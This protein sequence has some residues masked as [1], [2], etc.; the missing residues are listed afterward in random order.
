MHDGTIKIEK[1]M[2]VLFQ[3]FLVSALDRD[4]LSGVRSGRFSPR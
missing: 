4:S 2:K 1:R 3:L